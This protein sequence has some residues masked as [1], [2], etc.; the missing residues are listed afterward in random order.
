MNL[1]RTVLIIFILVFLLSAFTSCG[2]VD[3]TSCVSDS[4]AAIS[5]A[6]SDNSADISET[7]GSEDSTS[8]ED[9]SF[10]EDVSDEVQEKK[11]PY[12]TERDF[13][14]IGNSETMF[15]CE[16]CPG[17]TFVLHWPDSFSRLY[18]ID[19]TLLT[20]EWDGEEAIAFE[21]R[22]IKYGR[23]KSVQ[24]SKGLGALYKGAV[25]YFGF[26]NLAGVTSKGRLFIFDDPWDNMDYHVIAG[27]K[28]IYGGS[29]TYVQQGQ[30][31]Y[32]ESS[33][34]I[35]IK[36]WDAIDEP[37]WRIIDSDGNFYRL[38][39]PDEN[40]WGVDKIEFDPES[41]DPDDIIV[42]YYN[43]DDDIVTIKA[44]ARDLE[45]VSF[46]EYY[47]EEGKSFDED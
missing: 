35:I 25:Y 3:D 36:D 13:T 24:E 16:K 33:A 19:K 39:I 7:S 1:R 21:G 23:D 45:I 28:T 26:E 17:K 2:T 4:I 20:S 5:A 41:D 11:I 37:S 8:E 38:P 6:V 22:L 31:F 18:V 46:D 32:S 10:A 27:V 43:G 47:A 12:L 14:P 29:K 34:F 15:T 44:N 9:T 42:S 30:A 40:R